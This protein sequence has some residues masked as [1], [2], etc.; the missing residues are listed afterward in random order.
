[1]TAAGE[2]AQGHIVRDDDDFHRNAFG[3][4]EFGGKPEIE[5]IARVVLHDEHGAARAGRCADRRENGIG[6]RGREHLAAYRRAQHAR[7][8]IAAVR[9]FVP[10]AAA[11]DDRDR[12]I[13]A[14]RLRASNQYVFVAEQGDVRRL[15]RE[16]FEHFAHH[17]GRIV[18]EFLH[19]TVP[20]SRVERVIDFA[21]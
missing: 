11:R 15:P 7:A 4:R 14:C 19:G 18:D 16:S 6:R 2:L 12:A 9:G 5:A 20:P 21:A 17:A 13:I 10:A 8:D 3:A 1:M